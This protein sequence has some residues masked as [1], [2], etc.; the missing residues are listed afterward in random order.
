MMSDD[1]DPQHLSVSLC[2]IARDKAAV[3]A[4]CLDSAREVCDQLVVLDT[5]SSD[6]TV[7]IALW[8]RP[9]IA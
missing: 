9:S 2:M 8:R 5:G 6:D 3:I 7:A 1:R 4:G